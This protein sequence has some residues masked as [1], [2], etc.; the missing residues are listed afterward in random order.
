MRFLITKQTKNEEDMGLKLK[1]VWNYFFKFF[2]ANY[3]SSS[4]CVFGMGPL[5][6]TLKDICSPPLCTSNDTKMT[7]FD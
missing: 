5:L 2:E 4:S 6:L 1:G 7:Q 3:H